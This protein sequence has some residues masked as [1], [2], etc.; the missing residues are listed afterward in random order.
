MTSSFILH[1]YYI[2]CF[3]YFP[4]FSLCIPLNKDR[5]DQFAFF[6]FVITVT[7]DTKRLNSYDWHWILPIPLTL[8]MSYALANRQ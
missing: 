8:S 5:I 7:V 3:S 2:I 6:S 4:L 1:M